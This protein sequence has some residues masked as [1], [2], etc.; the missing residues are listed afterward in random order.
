MV[1]FEELDKLK[2]SGW[3]ILSVEA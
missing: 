1:F 3:R 2:Q